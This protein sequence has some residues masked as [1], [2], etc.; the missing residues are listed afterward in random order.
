MWSIRILAIIIDRMI[1]SIGMV[2]DLD[3]L[4]ETLETY[5]IPVSLQAGLLF[6]PEPIGPVIYEIFIAGDFEPEDIIGFIGEITDWVVRGIESGNM[7]FEK[8]SDA[9]ARNRKKNYRNN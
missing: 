5:E 6:C 2:N 4:L 1:Y 9:A 3:G 8:P 7:K